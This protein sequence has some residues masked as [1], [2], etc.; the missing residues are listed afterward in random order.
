M[1]LLTDFFL[2]LFRLV[3]IIMLKFFISEL[4]VVVFVPL[5]AA[6]S[7]AAVAELALQPSADLLL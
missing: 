2:L 1:G 4:P 5:D 7:S 3:F 6:Q